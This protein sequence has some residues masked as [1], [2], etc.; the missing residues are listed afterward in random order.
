[1]QNNVRFLS[2]FCILEFN[3][4]DFYILSYE[5]IMA[6]SPEKQNQTESN[7]TI[8][9]LQQEVGQT[10]QALDLLKKDA[11]SPDKQ[12]KTESMQ[13]QISMLKGKLT[14]AL[15]KETDEAKKQQIS[16]L[17]KQLETTSSELASLAQTV[18]TNSNQSSQNPDQTDEG[19]LAK[20]G[21][22]ISENVNA[23]A[24][25]DAWKKETGMNILRTAGFAAAG[26]AAWSGIKGAWNWMF[27]D[28]DEE[29]K[30]ENSDSED[31][32][33]PKKKDKKEKKGFWKSGFGQVLKWTGITGVVGTAG[34]YLGKYFGRWG[35]EADKSDANKF[36]DYDTFMKEHPE[37]AERY[38]MLWGS[39]DQFYNSIYLPELSAGYQD[40][41]EM[42]RIS[43]EQSG[44]TKIYKGVI[45]FCL[46]D[47]F[48]TVDAI[49]GQN[50]SMKN[51]ISGGLTAMVQYVKNLG[52]DF[53]QKFID[54]YLSKLP[55]WM[56][57][58]DISGTA[59]EKLEKWKAENQQA[60]RELQYFFRQSIRVQTYLMEKKEQLI[61]KIATEQSAL[62]GKSKEDLLSDNDL[63][64]KYIMKDPQYQAFMSSPLKSST[65]I[66]QEKG[67]FDAQASD[68]VK[69]EVEKL[70]SERAAVLWSKEWE[71][72]VLQSLAEKKVANQ[73]PTEEEKKMLISSCDGIIKEVDN[74]IYDAAEASAWNIYGDLLNTNDAAVREY[75]GKSGLEKV[76][77]SYKQKIREAQTKLKE[78]KLDQNQIFA[79]SDS[80]NNMLALKKE[81]MIWSSTIQKD[82]DENGNVVCRIPGFCVD[83]LSNL[84]RGVESLFGGER[85][86]AASYLSS[87]ALWTGLTLT[88]VGG[89]VYIVGSKTIGKGM[90]KTGITVA[91]LPASLAYLWWKVA[92]NNFWPGR[93]LLDRIHYGMPRQYLSWTEFKWEKG[94][95]NLMNAVKRGDLKLAKAEEIMRGKTSGLRTGK[96]E[97]IWWDYFGLPKDKTNINLA[98]KIFDK[99]VS[100]TK[101]TDAFLKELKQD[102]ELYQKVIKNFDNGNEIRLAITGD[103][104]IEKLKT[105]VNNLETKAV[106]NVTDTATDIAEHI[107]KNTDVY[108]RLSQD[109]DNQLKVLKNDLTNVDEARKVKIEGKLN[110]LT[111]FRD[112]L[113]K[114][115]EPELVKSEKL[116]SI[117]KKGSNLSHAAEQLH[118]LSKLE[119]RTFVSLDSNTGKQLEKS[120]DNVIKT[121]DDAAI[122][123]L[124]GKNTGIADE[125]LDAL[126]DTF[127]AAK[128]QKKIR[129]NADEFLSLVKA[130]VKFFS[131]LT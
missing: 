33:T 24:S 27:G 107:A 114:K 116:L 8:E 80:I 44:N 3:E 112:D 55:S 126:A 122:R 121:L 41:L 68:Y 67:I 51:A 73:V 4:D 6:N 102:P 56:P 99:Y 38:E 98:E 95:E 96:S 77:D 60:Q 124:K 90:I 119:G 74:K 18:S 20:T 9:Q 123:A 70:N 89:I 62:T 5:F 104:G 34:Y 19:F 71:K 109:F 72:D 13:T 46:D 36:K 54:S 88:V 75:L 59:E 29:E 30:E 12:K 93:R 7:V 52:T 87:S 83:S 91:T 106:S 48:G 58:A 79:L 81:I 85:M 25:A 110:A 108:K 40:E 94:P 39:V 49:L 43:K 82:I 63:R 65:K 53:V 45:P 50:S 129:S 120:F 57:F 118:T 10:Q 76:L 64:E 42:A 97:K 101:A 113:L 16:D 84:K 115:A 117:F 105:I 47:K 100:G 11:Q 21:D 131:K 125:A 26:Y 15:Q 128:A 28:K 127:K 92:L 111:Q 1:M 17:Q 35:K 14:E 66:L 23:V 61:D 22:F 78:G 130:T 103:E 31:G 37:E 69:T 2:F 86:D 32:E